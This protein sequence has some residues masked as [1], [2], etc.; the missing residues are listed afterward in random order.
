MS[1]FKVDDN[2]YSHPKVM[3]LSAR[4]VSLW[5]RAG[6]WSSY[7]STDG[8]IPK[9]MLAF[10]QVTKRTAEELVNSGL[11]ETSEDRG[12]KFHNWECY[13]PTKNELQKL[14]QKKN[15]A[16]QLGAA[17]TNA[18]RWGTPIPEN[19]VDSSSDNVSDSLSDNE[20]IGSD[21]VSDDFN[22]ALSDKK[23]VADKSLK[24]RPVPV[25]VIDNKLSI[26]EKY[27]KE[28]PVSDSRATEPASLLDEPYTSNF[29]QFWALY[30]RKTGKREAFKAWKQAG[31]NRPSLPLL[32]AKLTAYA[33]SREVREG[34]A[35]NASRW[36]RERRWEDQPEPASTAPQRP[37]GAGMSRI[38]ANLEHNRQLVARYEAEEAAQQARQAEDGSSAGA[39]VVPPL[40]LLNGRRVA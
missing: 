38:E 35:L 18:R 19:L 32:L 1:W 16:H 7:Y 25:P 23:S 26:K 40:K 8:Y 4:A 2:F 30:P 9:K 27:K 21:N 31:A 12:Y 10:F 33:A 15:K 28:I 5:V 36:I 37:S 17:K 29:E 14:K 22:I 24:G 20:D 34:Y 39:G 6:S 3:Q 11:W 13:Q